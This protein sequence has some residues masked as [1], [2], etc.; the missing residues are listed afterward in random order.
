MIKKIDVKYLDKNNRTLVLLI[1]GNPSV[2][3]IY[4]PFLDQVIKDLAIKGDTIHKVLPHLGQT[5]E[6]QPKIKN[7][8]VQ[9]VIA[10]H[11]ENILGLI[12][13]HSPTRVI[14]L[15]HSLG[16]AVAICLYQDLSEQIDQFIILCPFLGPSKNNEKYLRLFQNPLSK[17]TMKFISHTGL[18]H[19]S[20]SKKIFGRWL[21]DNPFN[22]LIAREI[23]KPNYL[24]HFFSLV[25]N[26]FPDFK[27]LDIKKRV[28]TMDPAKTFFLF[29]PNDFWVPD[30]SVKYLPKNSK[31]I[32]CQGI[33]HDFCL[34][35]SQY[36]RVSQAIKQHLHSLDP[37]NE[38]KEPLF[39][40]E[41][42][43]PQL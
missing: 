38:S 20:L 4:E 8:H 23:K 12:K 30:D 15:G 19:P 32:L 13:T 42:Q 9:D 22:E 11:L 24:H 28:S 39:E 35:S 6:S 34:K 14:L 7:I 1:P 31:S 40:E 43:A 29:A 16:S 33:A 17:R 3:G 26:Y 41:I 21:G 25:S 37:I 27:D 5:N 18:I 2:P 10:D 36:Q